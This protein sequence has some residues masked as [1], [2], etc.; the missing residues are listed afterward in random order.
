M[1]SEW[2]YIRAGQSVGPV[3]PSELK[4]MAASGQL[5]PSDLVWKEG[6][7]NWRKAASV[8][9]LFPPGSQPAR[10]VPP[11]LSSE[12]VDEEDALQVAST[13]VDTAKLAKAKQNHLYA[14]Q[15][16][17]ECQTHLDLFEKPPAD[18]AQDGL[19]FIEAALRVNPDSSD[20]WNTK[21]LLLADGL[22]KYEEALECLRRALSLEPDSILIKQNIQKIEALLPPTPSV[23][24]T[25]GEDKVSETMHREGAEQQVD[26]SQGRKVGIALGLGIFF[27]PYVFAW[28]TLR[29]GHTRGARLLS[30]A[31]LVMVLLITNLSSCAPTGTQS[32][33]TGSTV[34]TSSSTS[35]PPPSLTVSA[36]KI[37]SEYDSNEVAADR[38][39]K[40]KTVEISR[41]VDRVGKDILGKKEG[42]R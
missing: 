31:W 10:Q 26:Q 38:K 41:I 3:S 40:G 21:G 29:K 19:E 24:S 15:K 16:L 6:L 18:L 36:P 32:Y 4:Q 8:K 37:V 23:T 22:S 33:R 34:P 30:F 2:F 28:F 5:K 7:P 39:Y 11:P 1:G 13:S 12:A 9:G 20:Y 14:R 25:E 42:K 35:S 17:V 27:L